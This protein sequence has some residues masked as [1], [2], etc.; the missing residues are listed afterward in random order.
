MYVKK[1]WCHHITGAL[2]GRRACF[3]ASGIE[4]LLQDRG[5]RAGGKAGQAPTAG[6]TRTGK[7]AGVRER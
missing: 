5:K 4:R 3:G 1:W 7:I 2:R 6:W